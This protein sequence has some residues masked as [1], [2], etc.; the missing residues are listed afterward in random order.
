MQ[1]VTWKIERPSFWAGQRIFRFHAIK[2][3][4]IVVTNSFLLTMQQSL[5]ALFIVFVF[6]W[7]CEA[8]VKCLFS[9]DCNFQ[10]YKAVKG[11]IDRERKLLKAI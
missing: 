5:S 11:K 6:F 7:E 2:T 9:Q 10:K 4:T 8:F 3:F 1:D